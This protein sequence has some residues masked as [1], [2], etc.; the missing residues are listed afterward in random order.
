MR[1]A[2]CKDQNFKRIW[3]YWVKLLQRRIFSEPKTREMKLNEPYSYIKVK[4]SIGNCSSSDDTLTLIFPEYEWPQILTTDNIEERER[5]CGSRNILVTLTF[6]WCLS[7]SR[8]FSP[9]F[10]SS[11]DDVLK[12]HSSSLLLFL[13][14][15]IVYHQTWKEAERSLPI[16]MSFRNFSICWEAWIWIRDIFYTPREK[17]SQTEWR[18]PFL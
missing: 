11:N 4:F 16:L 1:G 7:S 9:S 18:K 10:Q 17:T 5:D 6:W 2:N 15:M 12:N 3:S 8:N 13:F 14:E